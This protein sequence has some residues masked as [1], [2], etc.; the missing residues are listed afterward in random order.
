[1]NVVEFAIA[2]QDARLAAAQAS[3]R[4]PTIEAF[5]KATRAAVEDLEL[6][7]HFEKKGLIGEIEDA[8]AQLEAGNAHQ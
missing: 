4:V 1:V 3:A 5:K 8:W 2:S 7:T 6:F